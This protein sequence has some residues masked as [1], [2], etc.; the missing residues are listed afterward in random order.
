[1]N[2]YQITDYTRQKAKLF[3]VLINASNKKNYK[4]DIFDIYGKYMTSI[5]NKKYK[6][7]PTYIK[8]DGIEKALERRRLYYIRHKKDVSKIGSR[9][10]WAGV[11]LW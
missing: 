11:L 7:F 4:I 10:Y 1:M 9:G 2:T 3:N 5:G 8:E 6:D